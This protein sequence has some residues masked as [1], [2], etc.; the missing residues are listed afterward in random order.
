MP[1]MEQLW[2]ARTR[3][4]IAAALTPAGTVVIWAGLAA[5][6]LFFVTLAVLAVG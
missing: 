4:S 3:L 6:A 5:D 1:E 2:A